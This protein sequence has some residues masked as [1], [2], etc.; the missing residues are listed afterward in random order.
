M[1]H[2]RRATFVDTI[3]DATIIRAIADDPSKLRT[4]PLDSTWGCH[5]FECT[6]FAWIQ[7]DANRRTLGVDSAKKGSGHGL[8]NLWR[9][10]LG[11]MNIHLPPS[12]IFTW[13]TGCLRVFLGLSPGPFFSTIGSFQ[14]PDLFPTRVLGG[15]LE[16]S[17]CL[18]S[19][20]T[21]KVPLEG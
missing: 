8:P 6:P 11:W 9:A 17:G 13:G 16:P 10:T 20:W 14:A 15:F 5:S 1:P 7:R 21:W 3:Y 19:E 18:G 2:K 4:F 12:L